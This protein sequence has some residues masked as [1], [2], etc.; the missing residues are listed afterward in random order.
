MSNKSHNGTMQDLYI[1]M[2]INPHSI[3]TFQKNKIGIK[4]ICIYV[5]IMASTLPTFLTSYCLN[6][7]ILH[8]N[9]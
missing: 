7:S 5:Y 1:C 2:Y 3:K 8:K 4:N 6:I 9:I